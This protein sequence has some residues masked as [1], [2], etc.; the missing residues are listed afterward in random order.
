MNEID[1]Y[2]DSICNKFNASDK[3]IQIL[4]EELKSN[5]YDEAHG[6]EKQ[7]FSEEE[8]IKITLEN[9]GQENTVISEMSSV[10]KKKS[11]FT[12][13][14]LKVAIGIFIIGCIFAGARIFYKSGSIDYANTTSEYILADVY[15]QISKD[16]FDKVK[17]SKVLDDFNKNTNNGLY[18]IKVEKANDTI[19]EYQKNVP[20]YLV[21]DAYEGNLISS[22]NWTMY[23]K[24]TDSQQITD[25]N[26]LNKVSELQLNAA[27]SVLKNISYLF[28]SISWIIACIV[29]Y[30]YI[31][32]QYNSILLAFIAVC[33]I[34]FGGFVA[35][36]LIFPTKVKESFI[37][38]FGTILIIILAMK[39]YFIKNKL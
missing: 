21:K 4:K 3:D 17:V 28:F 39:A 29:F 19:Y 8:S 22:N 6:L 1:W 33:D 20:T 9:F 10:W 31:N 7:G 12:L 26:N 2:V 11:D 32:I 37:I 18:F 24:K 14:I 35:C 36:T 27:D 34:G 13:M 15:S 38:L 25:I 16:N 23:Y 5:L 30:Q